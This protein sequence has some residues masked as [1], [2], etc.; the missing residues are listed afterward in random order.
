[1]TVGHGDKA[2]EILEE[3]VPPLSQA[4]KSGSE[5]SKISVH[6]LYFMFNQF[7]FVR[8]ILMQNFMVY[9]TWSMIVVTGVFGYYHFCWWQ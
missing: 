6:S 2:H 3:S 4:L 1:M 9:L 8:C 5:S 7:V